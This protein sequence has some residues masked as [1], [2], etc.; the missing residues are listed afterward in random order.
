MSMFS[1][2]DDP[3]SYVDADT[4]PVKSSKIDKFK[5][6]NVTID[7]GTKVGAVEQAV[8]P[9]VAEAIE[10]GKKGKFGFIVNPAM[11]ALEFVGEKIVQPATQTVSAALL[12]PQA[13]AAGK[14]GL[15]ESYRY[16]QKQAK[17]ISMGQA[18]A[19]AVGQIVSPVLGKVSEVTFLQEDFDVFDKKQRD[20]AFRDEWAGIVASG[21]TDLA[22]AAFGTK[23]AGAVVR[24]GAKKVVGPKRLVTSDDMDVFRREVNDAVEQSTLPPEQQ[25]KTGLTVLIDDAVKESNLTKLAANPL[26][27]ETSNPYRTATILS[28]LDNHQDVA[29][30]LLAERGDAVAFQRFFE[31]RPLEADHLDNYGIDNAT[32]ISNFANVGLDEL[33]PNLVQR[34]QRIIDAKKAEDPNFARALDDFME[35]AR[36]GVIESYRPGR[37]AALESIGLAKKKLQTQAIYGDLKMF[38]QDADGGWRTQVYQSRPYDRAIRVIAWTGSGRPQGYINISN[39]RKFEAANDLVSDLNRLQFLRGQEGSQ[40]KRQ[41]VEMFLDAQ[42]DTQRAIVLG[43]IEDQ[44]MARLAKAYGVTDMQDIRSAQ[45]A[46]KEIT[47]W[48]TRMN[49]TRSSIKDFAV[50]NGFIPED[51]TINVQNFLSV[52]NEAQNIPMLDFRRLELEVIFNA[53]RIAGKGA[54]VSQAQFAGAIASKTFMNVGQFLD[55]ANMVFS[56]LNLLRLAYIPKNSMV[57]PFARASMA[58]ESMELVQNALPGTNNLIYNTSLLGER[59]KKW[60]PGSP[61]ANARRQAKSAQFRV[62]KYRADLEPKIAAWETAQTRYDEL[63]TQFAKLT[64]QRD[65]ARAK[66]MKSKDVAVQ[67]RYYELED[68][69]NDLEVQLA[70]SYDEMGRLG[71]QVNGLS[72]LIERERADWA[73]WAT[74]QGNLTQKKLL[75]QEA[76]TIEVNGKTYTIQGL[77]DPN[78]RGASAYMA[79]IDTATNFYSASMQSEIARRLRADGTRF[80]K[81]PRKNRE[82]YMNALAHIANRQIRNELDMPLGMM[83]RGESQA[84]ILKWLY[85]PTGKEYR[86]RMESRFGRELTRDDFAAWI[87]ETTDKVYKMYPS[88]DLRKIILERPVTYQEVDAMLF[89]RTDLL[90]EI[91]G[92]SLKLSDLNGTERTLARVASATNWAWSKLAAAENRLV[93]NPLFLSYARDEMR[94]LINAAQRSGIDVSDA[95]V[96]NE[97]RQVAYRKALS[98][99]EETLYSSRR[100]T[101]GMYMAR[102]AMSF[103]LAFFNSQT[104]ALRLLARNPMNAYWYNSIQQA[105]DKY[106]AYEDQDGNTYSSIKDVPDGVSVTV[107]YPLPFGDKLPNWAKNALKPYT[108]P[109][110]GGTR[111]NPKQLEFMVADPSIS[112]FGTATLS[113]IID[114]GL[115]A[116]AWKIYGEDVAMALRNTLGDDIYESSILYGGY[117]TEGKNFAEKVKNTMVPGYMQSLVDS[118]K[119]PYPIR[120]ALSIIGLEKSERFTDEVFAH[121]RKGFSDWVANGRIGQPPTMETAAKAAGNMAFIRS[122]VQFSAPISASFDP[123]TRAATAYY[124]DLLEAANGDYKVADRMMMEDWGVDSL[125]LVGSNKKNI[126]GAASTL[127]DIKMLRNN[128]SLLEE[129]G[130]INTK[131]AGMLSSGY[132]D[133]AGTGSG[134]SDYSTEIASIYKRMNF[135][136]G[137]DN[138]ITQKKTSDELEKST[139]ARVGWAEYQKAVDWR[140]SMMYQYGIGSTYETRYQST[141]IKRM[142]DDMVKDIA[143]DYP[144]WVEERRANQKDYWLG[145]IPVIEKIVEDTAWRAHSLAAGSV[146]WEEI[147]FWVSKANKFKSD[148]N[149]AL[150]SDERKFALKQQFSQFHHDF[151]QTASD[152]FDAFASRWLNNMPELDTEYVVTE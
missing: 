126:A 88:E 108:D 114:N 50:K 10:S 40:F 99:V 103:P 104:V 94:V 109:R 83:L 76:E 55:L 118:G 139:Q 105:F 119:L 24:G 26:V 19:S 43:R 36:M 42:D 98:R 27:A 95:V 56:N 124:A 75:G 9:K 49:Q 64:A 96:N 34:Y 48:H 35:K 1:Q 17:K 151:L 3:S 4:K 59:L 61:A 137:Y 80:V 92:P 45:D 134:P 132:G 93:R 38:G 91:D 121:W 41:M 33:A 6:N 101:N 115:G 37:Y 122:V 44:V 100:L 22:L 77:A 7:D 68:A 127:N 16:S 51:G 28:R 20:K 12:T 78:V 32:P 65:K 58:L 102:Y 89:G 29:D 62:E 21:A 71:D 136:G 133:I 18:A 141:G 123:A 149:A 145:T 120:V 85:S 110:G 72:Q 69:L 11:R 142:Y 90:E 116:G 15:T 135:P 129:I 112:W 82:E 79:E 23:G 5:K 54:K 131:Y 140:N 138:P 148:Y 30:Y 150:N 144:G 87:D 13:M 2:W 57:D 53:R 128:K 152:E 97:I 111:F 70:Q 146:K 67:N 143:K 14:G 81:I 125:A 117:P 66:A 147:A 39:P 60:V 113:E 107:K 84:D 106:Q 73:E 86:L 63:D 47:R 46:I 52:A 74:A 31:R 130:R 25:V 8:I